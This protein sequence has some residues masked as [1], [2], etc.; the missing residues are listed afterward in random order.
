MSSPSDSLPTRSFPG[1]G[2]LA[3]LLPPLNEQ[4]RPFFDALRD[5]RF[6]LQR[7]G[8]CGRVRGLI[9][10]VCPHCGGES[11]AF[12]PMNGAGTVHSWIRYRRS[13]LPAFEA[14]MPYVVLCVALDEGAR[15]FG[16]LLDDE[17]GGSPE[18]YFGMPVELVLEQWPDGGVVHAF[19]RRREH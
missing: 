3:P 18:P 5:G 9:A 17:P 1:T 10:P 13:Y 19:Q 4:S 11:F 2:E 14:L 6:V 8:M 12:E 15:I 7:C 16:R